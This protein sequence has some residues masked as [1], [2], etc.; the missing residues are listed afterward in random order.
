MD[1]VKVQND[2]ISL[3]KNPKLIKATNARANIFFLVDRSFSMKGEKIALLNKGI[4]ELMD[5]LKIY[6]KSQSFEIYIGILQFDSRATWLTSPIMVP[7]STY[8]FQD[9]TANEYDHKANPESALELL[10]D[11]LKDLF[12][13][14]SIEKPVIFL[15]SDGNFQKSPEYFSAVISHSIQ[16]FGFK[17]PVA[18]GLY[19]FPEYLDIDASTGR[20]K[21]SFIVPEVDY[22]VRELEE[23]RTDL[24]E[25]YDFPFQ[26]VHIS[27]IANYCARYLSF[28]I[29]KITPYR[30]YVIF[31]A[32]CSSS[33]KGIRIDLLNHGIKELLVFLDNFS[34]GNALEPY[35]GI[36]QFSTSAE[37]R[38]YPEI[39]PLSSFEFQDLQVQDGNAHF[40]EALTL[41]KP[42]LEKI[43]P[44]SRVHH[45]PK[46][47]YYSRFTRELP[48]VFLLS[49]GNFNVSLENFKKMIQNTINRK[50]IRIPIIVDNNT[51]MPYQKTMDPNEPS[52]MNF[53]IFPEFKKKQ[54]KNNNYELL[55][56]FC[57]EG[58]WYGEPITHLIH[59]LQLKEI[60]SFFQI[61]FERCTKRDE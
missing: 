41:L 30:L 54:E 26:L 22:N 18:I 61:P 47:E 59:I 39:V 11:A 4:R 42:L 25:K 37:W 2:P 3:K 40:F 57:P 19:K 5:F 16:D 15:F 56:K 12:W 33:M 31:V 23:F 24:S 6:S 28:P 8:E 14:Q 60:T 7:V 20:I 21:E 29:P 35:I 53:L 44:Y 55:E 32:D 50:C 34:R 27:D 45:E 10:C 9:L 49:D 52:E 51:W 58:D 46:P 17:I 43:S 38:T 36:I 48:I 1:M 13:V